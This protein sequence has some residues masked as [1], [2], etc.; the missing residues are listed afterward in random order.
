[1]KISNPE[2]KVVRF[3]ADDVI[4]TSG[5]LGALSGQSGLFYIPAGQYS[6]AY[7]GSGE[8]VEFSGTF[9]DYDGS[10]YAIGNISGAK[11]GVDGDR[12]GLIT[13]SSNEN[14]LIDLG[15]GYPIPASVLVPTAQQTY[16]AYSYG[17]GY[18]SN[19]QSYYDIYHQ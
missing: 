14:A 1:M 4:A 12:N 18:Y 15:V 8:Y 13:A 3:G 2:L 7:S 16:D 5:L 9:G 19:G 11:G 17:G 10:N 6:G